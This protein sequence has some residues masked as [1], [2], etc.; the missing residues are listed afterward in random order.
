M[1]LLTLKR[2]TYNLEGTHGVII[3]RREPLVVTM[4]NPWID[5]MIDYSCIPM[6]QY[7]CKRYSSER[8]SDT[9]EIT[10]VPERT[11]IV[12]HKG[13][14]SKDTQGCILV[15]SEFGVLYEKPAILRSRDAF[16]KFMKFTREWESFL[17]NIVWV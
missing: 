14:T 2:I 8:F 9:F 17:L 11:H 10:N 13:N 16:K 15:G 5:N 12:F 1:E 4:E 3:F 7:V 6:G